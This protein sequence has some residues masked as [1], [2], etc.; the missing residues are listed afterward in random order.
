MHNFTI[1]TDYIF[2]IF[3]EVLEIFEMNIA[4]KLVIT[5]TYTVI[6][7]KVVVKNAT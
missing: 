5:V 7:F 6:Q 4:S 1:P 2:I 3:A